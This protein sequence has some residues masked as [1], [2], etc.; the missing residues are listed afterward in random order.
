MQTTILNSMEIVESSPNRYKSLCEKEKLLVKN[1]FFF[2][3]SGFKTLLQQTSKNHGLFVKWVIE[4]FT[5]QQNF[6]LVQIG[7][8]CRQQNECDGNN[9]I[10]FGK[11]ENILGKGENAGCQ[12]FLLFQQCFQKPILRL[13][14]TEFQEKNKLSVSIILE[15]N[16]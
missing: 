8:I 10:C 16:F 9:G 4:D 6:R 7:S 1:N 11:V 5:K 15:S 12:H 14:G 3:H 2:S 13:Y